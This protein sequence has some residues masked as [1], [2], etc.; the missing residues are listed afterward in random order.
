MR[1][2]S[3]QMFAVA[4]MSLLT[5]GA[6][7]KLKRF[8]KVGHELVCT[9]G[10]NQ[11]LL[12]CNHVGCP[13]SEGM[14][15]DLMAR[16]HKGETNEQIMAAFSDRFGPTVLAAPTTAGFNLVAWVVPPV[17]LSLGIFMA[18]FFVRRWSGRNTL[19]TAA[20]TS[21]GSGKVDSMRLRARQETE[22]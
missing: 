14:R 10:C 11:I 7:P 4:M 18:I 6:D 21:A 12:E 8:E 15:Q 9:C 16:L 22:I 3:L 17:V 5:L 19:A 13:A 1:K 2:R 20:S